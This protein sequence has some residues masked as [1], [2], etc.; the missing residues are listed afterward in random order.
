[1]DRFSFVVRVGMSRG[2]NPNTTGLASE[3]GFGDVTG[4]ELP[5]AGGGDTDRDREGCW[6]SNDDGG[7]FWLVKLNV[8]TSRAGTSLGRRRGIELERV[9]R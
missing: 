2:A 8:E 9:G 7:V 4:V 3:V 5:L 1:M 6:E